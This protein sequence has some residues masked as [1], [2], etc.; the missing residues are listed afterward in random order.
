[1]YSSSINFFFLSLF[2]FLFFYY[3]LF[4]YFFIFYVCLI[5]VLGIEETSA[6]INA[7]VEIGKQNIEMSEIIPLDCLVNIKKLLQFE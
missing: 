1:M 7:M 5:Q 2:I 6:R 4:N 3:I